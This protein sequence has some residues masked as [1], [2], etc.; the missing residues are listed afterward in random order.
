[1]FTGTFSLA[2]YVLSSVAISGNWAVDDAGVLLVNGNFVSFLQS[3]NWDHLTP[4]T[5]PNSAL[6]AGNNT[7]TV[8]LTEND[9]FLEGV[10]LNASGTGALLP[11]PEPDQ[12][13]LLLGG[14]ALIA[15]FARRRVSGIG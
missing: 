3:N 11:V 13:A 7:F 14:V 12:W 4:F 5:V 10:R 9:N 8:V 15:G 1:M 2:P 6:V